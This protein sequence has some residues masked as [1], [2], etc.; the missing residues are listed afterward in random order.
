VEAGARTGTVVVG[1][2]L[3]HNPY[4]AAYDFVPSNPSLDYAATINW[5]DGTPAS[6]G[7]VAAIGANN[8][9]V[10]GSHTYAL[11]GTFTITTTVTDDGGQPATMT[12]HAMVVAPWVA[13]A[14]A[15][16]RSDDPQRALLLPIGE[17]T[18]DINQGALR[19]S[20]TLDFDQSPGTAVGG[21]PALVYNSATVS[22]RPV[23]QVQVATDPQGTAPTQAVV[24]LS[25]NGVAQAPV[26][27]PLS[28]PA[29]SFLTLAVQPALPAAVSGAY[30]WSAVLTF[31]FPGGGTRQVTASGTAYVAV[32]DT[33]VYGPGWWIDVIP[34]LV[35]VPS[36]E[37]VAAFLPESL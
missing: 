7:T 15:G 28:A 2:F 12:G 32:R 24:V 16:T 20:H 3:D 33:S 29:G 23:V 11:T 8:F 17:A 14:G 30:A 19:L 21:D 34:Q 18:A 37:M 26:T 10:T 5:G 13:L 1:R 9:R 25:W 22:V 4:A 6:A 35:P 27:F 31:S 36:P